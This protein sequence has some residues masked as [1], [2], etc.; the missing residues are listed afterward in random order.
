MIDGLENLLNRLNC[1]GLEV[2][3]SLCVFRGV[4]RLLRSYACLITT[5]LPGKGMCW[6]NNASVL[7]AARPCQFFFTRLKIAA[8]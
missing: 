7:H 8:A 6:D 4:A 3:F 5:W 2:E 1:K